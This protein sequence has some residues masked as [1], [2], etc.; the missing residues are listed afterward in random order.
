MQANTWRYKYITSFCKKYVYCWIEQEK[1][2][3]NVDTMNVN[4]G[5]KT[6][7]KRQNIVSFYA[8]YG[9]MD[10]VEIKMLAAIQYFVE[11]QFS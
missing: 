8:R 9:Q 5:T 3:Y 2:V 10:D 7:P 1:I 4:R 6:I 11:L